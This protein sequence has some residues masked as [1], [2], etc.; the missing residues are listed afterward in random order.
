LT[1]VRAS[2][3][4]ARRDTQDFAPVLVCDCELSRPITGIDGRRATGLV[5]RTANVLVRLHHQP[6]GSVAIDLPGGVVDASTVAAVVW[7]QLHDAI[8]A[9]LEADGLAPVAQLEVTGIPG[10]DPA[11][12]Q[13]AHVGLEPLVSVVVPTRDRAASLARC[14]DSLADLD[15]PRL[16][17]I[18]VDNAPTT[19]ETRA[20]VERFR[21]CDVT[22]VR[23]DRP[24]ASAARNRGLREA[25]GTIVAFTDDDVLV[26]RYWIRALVDC[27]DRHPD[28]A[29]VT[30][31]V[32]PAELETPSQ[33]WFERYGG[34]NK[35]YEAQLYD[36]GDH[37]QKNW[38]YPYAAGTFGSGNNVAF[39]ADLLGSIGG[40]DCALGPG[41]PARAGED[42]ALF[43]DVITS[44][45]ALAYEPGAVVRHHHRAE[46]D[47]LRQQLR[48]YG[49]GLSAMLTAQSLRGFGRGLRILLCIPVGLRLLLSPSSTKNSQ[50]GGDYPHEL[51]AAEL[52]GFMFGPLAYLRSTRAARATRRSAPAVVAAPAPEPHPEP[53]TAPATSTQPRRLRKHLAVPLFRNA[54]A[55]IATTI[56][57]SI[58]GVAYWALAARN[59][60]ATDVG[61][62]SALISALLLVAGIAQLNLVNVLPRFLP[63]AGA[64]TRKLVTR[65][66]AVSAAA[67]CVAGIGFVVVAKLTGL[68]APAG[69]VSWN[70]GVWFVVAAVAWC[71]FTL[72]DS[73]LAG[74]RQAPWIPVENG[75]F[76]SVK[77]LLLLALA[78]VS[79]RYGLFL[80]FTIPVALSLIPVNWF[81]FR[82]AIPA[83]EARARGKSALPEWRHFRRFIAADYTG[84]LFQLG[85]VTILPLIVA[86]RLGLAA[87]AYFYVAWVVATAFDLVLSNIGVSFLVEGAHEGASVSTLA[88]SA[89]KL[90]AAL[91]LPAVVIVIVVAPYAL[92]FLGPDYA[93]HGTVLLRL[94]ALAAAFRAVNVLFLSLARVH[95]RV[96]QIVAVQALTCIVGL[97]LALVLL[98]PF[99]LP[100]AGLAV[101]IAQATTA[102]C[103]LPSLIRD[104]RSHD[105]RDA[106]VPTIGSMPAPSSLD[107]AAS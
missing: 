83:A 52:R 11:V 49:V 107:V 54:Y 60:S 46:Y 37:R 32:V 30:G 10:P 65:A 16:E 12:C 104:L 72:Q 71:I 55:L 57:T 102:V 17:I 69:D 15:Y 77:I 28:V 36:T 99:G 103:V 33:V 86:A 47:A 34:F 87:N 22:Y 66:Y 64:L 74:L 44:G 41:T 105:A 18:V 50:R 98:D 7:S 73:V 38:L 92:S 97:G 4:D 53:T 14:L 24:G 29:C 43:V 42:L 39:R 2:R 59:Y 70:V 58:L 63:A 19:E 27:F 68:L 40:Y 101:L 1:Q 3:R 78:S 48:D 5:H 8:G 21:G 56:V 89:A 75:L 45:H 82:R 93:E 25:Q 31:L 6:L 61:R 9:H 95:R 76:S 35:G 94:L 80:S 26:D 91:V 90:T 23:E 84:G 100:G 81:L 88:R 96:R 85:W 67:A 79:Q 51:A 106:A 62:T 13:E 20:C